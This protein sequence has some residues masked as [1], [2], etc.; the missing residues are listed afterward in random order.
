MR[1][2]FLMTSL[3][4]VVI[5]GT[6]V[7]YTVSV[8]L[9]H[10]RRR[11]LVA[12]IG[13]TLGIVPHLIAAVF[14]LSGF[15]H[16]GALA[17]RMLKYAGVIYLLFLAV[18]MFRSTGA[19]AFDNHDPAPTGSASI[20]ARGVLLNLLNPK[21]TVFFFAFLPQFVP[22]TATTSALL[23]LGA[24]FMVLTLGVFAIYA[25]IAARLCDAFATDSRGR[26]RLEKSMAGLLA[27][28]AVKLA[29]TDQ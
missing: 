9:T 13:C 14:G 10:G 11:G 20:V 28:F 2:E 26:R 17:F 5:P 25:V 18:S 8:A 19:T 24:V 16:A 15:L 4:V 29:F 21:L 12:A 7:I 1:L 6:G 27:G 23:G 3:I 22:S